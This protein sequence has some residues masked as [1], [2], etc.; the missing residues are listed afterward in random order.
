MSPSTAP[1]RVHPGTEQYARRESARPVIETG[2]PGAA[3]R[4]LLAEI[5]DLRARLA[6][7]DSQPARLDAAAWA[8]Y[9]DDCQRA[10]VTPHDTWDG[11]APGSRDRL[12]LAATAVVAAYHGTGTEEE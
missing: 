8:M 10:H 12:R 7:T 2:M 3:L 1:V 9:L 5:D 4:E 6:A 11:L